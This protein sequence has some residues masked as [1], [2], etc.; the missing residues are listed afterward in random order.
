VNVDVR[1]HEVIEHTADIG[2]HAEA[3]N[4]AA[5]LEEAA[6]ALSV[7][8]A[9]VVDRHGGVTEPFEVQA[10]DPEGLAYAW[11]N[12]LI[13]M[14]EARGEALVDAEVANLDHDGESWSAAGQARFVPFGL[15]SARSRLQV[16]AATYHRLRVAAEAEKWTLNAYLD[17]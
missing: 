11:L 12:E 1:Y 15:G 5:L 2:I 17:V 3:P 9:D 6:A 7:V 10:A 8:A 13:G 14:A 4:P 16:K